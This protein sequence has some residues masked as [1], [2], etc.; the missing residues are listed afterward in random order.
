MSTNELFYQEQGNEVNL[1]NHAFEHQLPVLIKGPTGCGKTRFIAHMA[2]KLNKPLLH[3][4][5]TENQ[6]I[7][8]YLLRHIQAKPHAK[9]QW[10]GCAGSSAKTL[11]ETAR[12]CRY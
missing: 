8:L 11:H 2:Q 3:S 12:H 4:T 6:N 1:F 10:K 9:Q 5:M 7:L